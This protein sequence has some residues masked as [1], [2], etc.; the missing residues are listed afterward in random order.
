MKIL[1]DQ[2][3]AEAGV[4]V[5]HHFFYGKRARIPKGRELTQHVHPYD[6]YSLL[7]AGIV[8]VESEGR[9]IRYLARMGPCCIEIKAGIAHK[10]TAITDAIWIC[11]HETD[12]TNPETVDRSILNAHQAS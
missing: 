10:V 11:L 7:V 8:D 9:S 5:S 12:D 3:L 1:T 4:E 6:H 2:D